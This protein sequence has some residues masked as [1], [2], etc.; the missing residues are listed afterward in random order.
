MKNDNNSGYKKFKAVLIVIGV[1]SVLVVL[2]LI[3]FTLIP[4]IREIHGF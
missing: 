2:H 3:I 4:F 1:I